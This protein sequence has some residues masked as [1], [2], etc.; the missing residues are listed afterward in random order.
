MAS[1][2]REK[3]T[4]S[5]IKMLKRQTVAIKIIVVGSLP[6]DKIVAENNKVF[7]IESPNNPLSLKWQLGVNEARKL[8]PSHLMICG[9]DVWLSSNWVKNS[10]PF[11]KDFNI[12]GKN[13]FYTC[14]ILP[15]EKIQIIHRGY[16]KRRRNNPV[17]S[18]RIYS[19]KILDQ[20]NWGLY[21]GRLNKGLD[22]LNKK[23]TEKIEKVKIIYDNSMINLSFKSTWSTIT[24]WNKLKK[25]KALK[26]FNNIQNPKKWISS[27]FPRGLEIIKGIEPEVKL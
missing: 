6:S 24:P 17:G 14:S 18:G 2:K 21:E 20:I 4:S 19:K 5:A 1:Y 7:Y 15:N 9:S 23:I 8:N 22:G 26:K 27:R 25:S 16:K 3:I 13:S 12:T 11:F 10:I